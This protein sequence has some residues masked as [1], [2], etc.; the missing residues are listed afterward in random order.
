MADLTLTF[1]FEINNSVQ[2]GDKAYYA[3]TTTSSGFDINSSNINELGTISSISK[4]NETNQ[5]IVIENYFA[6]ELVN[7]QVNVLP[8][9]PNGSYIFFSKDNAVNVSTLRGYYGLAKFVND[10]ESVGELFSVSC[11][12]LQSSK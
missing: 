3:P 6:Y 12:V 7:G 4:W 9:P 8:P 10:S 2:V 1:N 11:G 5:S